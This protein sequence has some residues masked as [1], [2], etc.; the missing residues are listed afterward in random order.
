VSTL[1][2]FPTVWM[3]MSVWPGV[4][5]LLAGASAG[6][7]RLLARSAVPRFLPC[8]PTLVEALN[9]IGAAPP[10]RRAEIELAPTVTSSKIA[11]GWVAEQLG[12]FGVRDC[13]T[14]VLVATELVENSVHH[15][16]TPLRLRLELHPA[17]L[18][19]AVSDQD[20]RP[21]VLT[22]PA[23]T[24]GTPRFGMALIEILARA[25]GHSPRLN[26]GKTVWAVLPVPGGPSGPILSTNA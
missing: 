19:V 8:H 4:P 21:P 12:L 14:A 22:H 18:T 24:A 7:G 10:W 5:L 23:A 13:E 20:E 25:W 2:L 9:S 26:G 17:G 6:L 15:A 3:R 16:G 11:R 1:S